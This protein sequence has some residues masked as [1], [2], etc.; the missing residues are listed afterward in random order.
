MQNKS[1]INNS[2]P[3]QSEDAKNLC[4]CRSNRQCPLD[5]KCLTSC[6]I[7]QASVIRPDKTHIETYIGL[8]E[9]SFKSRY[10]G[11]VSSFNNKKGRNATTLSEYIWKLKEKM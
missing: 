5:G 7:Y 10:T 8:T 6:V 4:N 3:K 9:N 2:Q 1:F 11:H